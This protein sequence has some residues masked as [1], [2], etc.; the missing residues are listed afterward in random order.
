M[1]LICFSLFLARIFVLSLCPTVEILGQNL[2][3]TL[4]FCWLYDHLGY[5]WSSRNFGQFGTDLIGTIFWLEIT[6]LSS[7][8]DGYFV[9]GFVPYFEILAPWETT[10]DITT[11]VLAYLKLGCVP[12]WLCHFYWGRILLKVICIYGSKILWPPFLLSILWPLCLTSIGQFFQICDP[13]WLCHFRLGPHITLSNMHIGQQST[14]SSLFNW[15]TFSDFCP[16]LTG[17]FFQIF[18]PIRLGCCSNL[19]RDDI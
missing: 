12:F 19:W 9:M 4:K 8:P 14:V 5:L 13:F 18:D 11:H 15:A 6:M 2:C 17:Q 7:L 3:P 1:S 16:T 10:F